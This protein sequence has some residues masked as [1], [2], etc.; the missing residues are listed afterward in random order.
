MPEASLLFPLTMVALSVALTGYIYCL[1]ITQAVQSSRCLLYCLFSR[2]AQLTDKMVKSTARWTY[3]VITGQHAETTNLDAGDYELVESPGLQHQDFFD[4]PSEGKHSFPSSVEAPST[5][6]SRDIPD[7]QAHAMISD[8]DGVGVDDDLL[9]SH[10]RSGRKAETRGSHKHQHSSDYGHQLQ[11]QHR[12]AVNVMA[13]DEITPAVWESDNT[14]R[15]DLG[16]LH[17]WFHGAVD[18]VVNKFLA[19]LEPGIVE[20]VDSV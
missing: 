1:E 4:T 16:R 10:V 19:K 3:N 7:S 12:Q 5:A 8:D 2:L 13:D 17:A 15:D 6:N 14:G 11:A 9:E 20:V 18:R